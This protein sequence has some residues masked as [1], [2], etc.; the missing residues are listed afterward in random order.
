MI[1][2]KKPSDYA[3]AFG[4]LLCGL[5]NCDA[6]V[7]FDVTVTDLRGGQAVGVKRLRGAQRYDVDIAAH[8]QALLD[9]APCGGLRVE[10][11]EKP[12]HTARVRV[13]APGVDSGEMVFTGA[14]GGGAAG[15]AGMQDTA[16]SAVWPRSLAPGEVDEIGFFAP[17]KQVTAQ[18]LFTGQGGEYAFSPAPLVAGKDMIAFV[19]P[20]DGLRDALQA[21]GQDIA[22]FEDMEVVVMVAGVEI[23]R[24]KYAL[25]EARPDS[26][27]MAWVDRQGAI[28]RHTFVAVTDRTTERGD[29][30]ARYLTKVVS[31]FGTPGETAA[32]SEILTSPRVWVES[33]AGC[34]PVEITDQKVTAAGDSPARLALT[35]RPAAAEVIRRMPW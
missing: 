1:L 25:T 34:F 15:W 27:R 5:E 18:L 12:G 20:Y 33:A 22:G 29:S 28:D 32:L 30:L 17:G 24:Q 31:D 6:A 35:L 10:F 19:L 11:V 3:S 4:P 26:V 21:D 9:P 23:I 8:V 2:S 7:S 13:T 14:C 16:R